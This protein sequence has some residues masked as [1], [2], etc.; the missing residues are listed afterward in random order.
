[1]GT[2]VVC[3]SLYSSSVWYDKHI[4]MY[5]YVCLEVCGEKRR[6]NRDKAKQEHRNILQEKSQGESRREIKAGRNRDTEK[7][8]YICSV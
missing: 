3:V 2:S 4:A 6:K 8:G 1:M 7:K 5:M